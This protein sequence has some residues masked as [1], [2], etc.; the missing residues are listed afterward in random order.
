MS[1]GDVIGR[2]KFYSEGCED[3]CLDLQ[4]LK[5][6]VDDTG[7]KLDAG[8]STYYFPTDPKNPKDPKVVH[9]AKQFCKLI[10]VPFSFFYKN[11]VYMK[12][13]LVSCWLPSLKPEKSQVLAKLRRSKE[14]NVYIIRA[15][16][17]VEYTNI[18]NVDVMEQV[19]QAICDDFRVEFS[20]GDERDDLILHVRFI[21]NE[22]FKAHDDECA[23][24]FSVVASELGASDLMIE[25]MLYRNSSQA[26][27]IASYS[28]ESFFSC[29]YTKIQAKDLKEL[30]PRIV[31]HLKDQLPDLKDKVLKAQSL[32]HEKE[33]VYKLMRDLR[34][35]KG[36]NEKFHTLLFQELEKSGSMSR[37]EFS[38]KVAALAKDFDV[39]KRVRIERVAGDLIGLTFEK[40]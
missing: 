32:V 10:G 28:G 31:S 7:T 15:L 33:D 1:I 23:Y 3:K 14:D 18:S 25:T 12:G 29:G 26:S 8:F 22:T 6:G 17:P 21:S 11:P 24:G 38:N 34:L 40:A 30:F 27:M 4:A 2:L 13:Y 36:L 16:L 35:R 5:F 39:T 20:I 19:S 9:S 37:W